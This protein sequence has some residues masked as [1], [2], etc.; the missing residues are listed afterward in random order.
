MRRTPAD[1]GS[2]KDVGCMTLRCHD[3]HDGHSDVHGR[4]RWD[5]PAPTLTCRCNSISNGRFAHPEQD[6]GMAVRE[7][8][9][10]QTFPDDY[11]L[12]SPYMMYNAAHV[13][14]AVPVL[15][16]VAL[17]RALVDARQR[18]GRTSRAW[19]STSS[20]SKGLGS[21]GQRRGRTSRAW[22]S[23]APACGRPLPCFL[24]RRPFRHQGR[25]G[26]GA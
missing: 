25:G 21:F 23:P 15:L 4:M 1:G 18:R 5:R 22:A 3:G 7:A 12:C 19:A 13:G 20:L 11:V 24:P 8:A 26:R 16:A 6:R 14:N 17:G 10:L 2:R 9:A